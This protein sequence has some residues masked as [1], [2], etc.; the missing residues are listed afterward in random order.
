MYQKQ[1]YKV[2]VTEIQFCN[3]FDK[4]KHRLNLFKNVIFTNQCL[5]I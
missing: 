3:S 5:L 1:I 2:L 4:A